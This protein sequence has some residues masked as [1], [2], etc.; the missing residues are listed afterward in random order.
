MRYLNKAI[1]RK[2]H[3]IPTIDVV[4]SDLNGCTVFSKIDLNQGYHQIPLHSDSRLLT[5]FSTHV[6][7]FRYKRLNFGLSSAAEIF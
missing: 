6:L 4:L 3:V 1:I 2:R 5:T 7:L